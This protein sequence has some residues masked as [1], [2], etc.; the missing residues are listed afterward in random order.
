M[1]PIL[2]VGEV[3]WAEAR[4]GQSEI[5]MVEAAAKRL[6]DAAASF[7]PRRVRFLCGPGNNGADGYAAAILAQRW[8]AETDVIAVYPPRSP[9]CI[10][11]AGQWAR[12]GFD[13]RPDVWVDAVFGSG[14]RPG[15]DPEMER[16]KREIASSGAP[17]VAAD[18]P[19]GLDADTGRAARWA[20]PAT[21]TVTMGFWKPG[22][23]FGD[24]PDLCGEVRLAE[25]GFE[26]PE[27]APLLLEPRDAAAGYPPRRR[28]AHKNTYGHLLVLAGSEGMAGAAAMCAKAALRGGAGL[29]TVACPRACVPPVQAIVP[30]AMCVPT[31]E[32]RDWQAVFRG[33]TAV[34]AG[35][36]YRGGA[37][38]IEAVLRSGLPAVL[39]AGALGI[40]AREEELRSLLSPIHVITPHP[41]EA[42]RL[43]PGLPEDPLEAAR[44]LARL[45]AVAVY[46]GHSTVIAGK[47][48]AVSRSGCPG[49]AKGGSGDALTGLIGG[50]LC[51]GLNPETAARCADEAHGLAGEAAQAQ[52]GDVSMTAMDLIGQVPDAIR[53]IRER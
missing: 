20:I 45:G 25:L 33:K 14:F 10:H 34:A 42:K 15:D 12:E 18:V 4:S 38:D 41:G 31:E 2:S 3:R 13:G 27:G 22:L 19:S 40:L 30:E 44:A 49:M 32:I 5:R 39:D 8:G 52:W 26:A 23:L 9:A 29:V 24:G 7:S 36:G 28:N 48:V 6:W 50:L 21:I 35:P 46:K 47:G 51:Q 53:R 11:F 1:K 16:L 17:V 37:E 43:I